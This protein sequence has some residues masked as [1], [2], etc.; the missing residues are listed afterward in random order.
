M[1]A[2]H[3]PAE[4]AKIQK[5]LDLRVG[6]AKRQYLEKRAEYDALVAEA[7]QLRREVE[8]LV[9]QY[10]DLVAQLTMKDESFGVNKLT[11]ISNRRHWLNHDREMKQYYLDIADGDVEEAGE[12]LAV[13][14]AIWISLDA[15]EQAVDTLRSDAAKR[16]LVV[17]ELKAELELSDAVVNAGGLSRG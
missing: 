11:D 4:L 3:S 12:E 7:D 15:R 6:R 10:D 17:E 14:K 8:G 16:A 1:S 2:N 5:V 13:L 9:D